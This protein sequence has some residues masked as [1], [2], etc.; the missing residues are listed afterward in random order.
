VRQALS[1][2]RVARAIPAQIAAVHLLCS[3]EAEFGYNLGTVVAKQLAMDTAAGQSL[4]L[5]DI[6]H[7]YGGSTAVDHV[8]LEIAAGELVALLGPS[9]C[10]KTTLLRV[11][12]GFIA[13]TSGKVVVGGKRIDELPPNRRNIGIVFQNY[14][15]FPHMTVGENVGYGLAA[16]GTDA[17]AAKKRTAE[18]LELVQ[19]GH[20]ADRLTK[21]LSGGQQQRVALARALAIEPRVLLLDEPFS[22]LDKSL[23]LDMQIEIKRIQRAAGTT[24]IIVTHDQEEALGMADRVAVLSQGRLEQ[25]AP[26]SEVYDTPAT[27]FVNQFVGTANVFPGTLEALDADGARVR[28]AD[29]SAMHTRAPVA[30]LALGSK[31]LACV[32][33]EN[34]RLATEG[35]GIAATVELGMPLGATIV[36]EIRTAADARLKL[37]EPRSPGTLPRASGASVWVRPVSAASVVLFPAP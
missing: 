18:M 10:G 3:V 33:P 6:V 12:A 28:L 15:L 8:T 37:V 11:I 25:F 26:P 23:R 14:A 21:Q 32:R 2:T 36:H 9:G 19:L 30:S 34:L 24:A 27:Y 35:D 4:T 31:V 5:D 22:A 29:G 7:R 20:L 13:Q 16:R 17:A 1:M